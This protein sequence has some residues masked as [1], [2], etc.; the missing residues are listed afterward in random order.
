ME[1]QD[2][3]IATTKKQPCEDGSSICDETHYEDHYPD[4]KQHKHTPIYRIPS[5]T[6]TTIQD[7]RD[8]NDNGIELTTLAPTTNAMMDTN[9]IA[10]QADDETLYE[11]C[12]LYT[13][14]SPR[15]KRQSRMPSSA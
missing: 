5:V 7:N 10:V 1:Q 14:P 8:S 2:E 6:I 11:A 12:L 13:S 9:I 15:D 4:K 3:V